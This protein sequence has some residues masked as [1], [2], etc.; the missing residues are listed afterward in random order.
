MD[1]NNDYPKGALHNLIKSDY[2]K[3]M[4]NKANSRLDRA[5]FEELYIT[6]P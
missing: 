5:K 4:E 2:N 1:L 6:Y 3:Y